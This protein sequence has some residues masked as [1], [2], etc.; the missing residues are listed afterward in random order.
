MEKVALSYLSKGKHVVVKLKPYIRSKVDFTVKDTKVRN[1]Y[2][3]TT[4]NPNPVRVFTSRNG[5]L[6]LSR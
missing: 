3:F 1:N 5:V 6:Q 4:L 2:S